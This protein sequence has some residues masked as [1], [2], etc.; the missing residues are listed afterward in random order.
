MLKRKTRQKQE[1]QEEF[2]V[3]TSH[4]LRIQDL[5]APDGLLVEFD[6]LRTGEGYI[7]VYALHGLPRRVQVGWLDEVFN[8]GE[9]DLSIHITPAPDRTVT[10]ILIK[11]E[12]KAKSQLILDQQ[13]GNISRLPE[14]DAQVA[15]YQA[16]R[17]AVQLGQDRLYYLTFLIAVHGATEEEL[18]RRC[19]T[20][21][22]IFAR[23]GV[24]PRKLVLRQVVGLKS[25]LPLAAKNIHDF[26]KNFTSGAAACCL[27]LSVSTGGH[28]SGVMLGVNLFT[29]APVFLDRFA[30]EHVV[31][32]QHIFISGEP[33]SGKS[34]TGR[35]L[36]LLEGYRGV[37]TAFVDPEGEYV[38][39]TESL[40][41]QAVTLR[42]GKF[43]GINPLDLEPEPEDDGTFRVNVLAKVEDLQGLVGAVF[44]YHS[45]EGMNVRE[46]ALLE[47]TA[48]EEYRER[49]ITEDPA[50]L[51]Q[52]GVKKAMPTLT[53]IQKRLAGKPGAE[54]L[55]D[56]M[57][58]LLAGGT[59]GMFDGQT[60]V[61]LQDA[62]F[63]C[64][65]LRPLG[66][67]FSR[68]IGVYATLSWL[69]Q[70]FA[71]KGG[72]AVPK[73]VAV[74]EAW[75]F[76]RHPDAALY[77]EILARRGRKHGCALTIATQRFEEFAS[78]KEGRAVI[79]SCASILVLKQEDHAAQAAVEY[80]KLA[81]GCTDLLSRARAG[82]GILRT[83][84]STTAVQVQP[85]PFEWE[86]VETKM[87]GR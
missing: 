64:F 56:A 13:S 47:E 74:D 57:K 10:R 12:S 8:V 86:F 51:Y 37:T 66:G 34:V 11:K 26:E 72:K 67:D 68:F 73:C 36:A 54:R 75:M 53:D 61:H 50:S 87:R 69:W 9:V 41:G 33:G 81:S 5:F 55:A 85:A 29:R 62:L 43:S 35:T 1:Q 17:E 30:G 19:E 83:S 71:Q 39:F 21:E 84:G 4:A 7:R 14:L 59:L 2:D 25:F 28:S 80:F 15:D 63:I 78:S 20:V 58:P 24:V 77:L 45:G 3:L 38:Y 31:S 52:N 40:G 46:A 70:F 60:M 65:N 23:R 32:N 16:L 48:R 22:T 6:R 82:Q 18:R 44:R 27:P 42:P 49:G 76:L 79:E